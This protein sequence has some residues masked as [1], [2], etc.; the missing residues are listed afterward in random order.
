MKNYWEYNGI[1]EAKE[2]VADFAK[3]YNLSEKEEKELF[4]ALLSVTVPSTVYLI[5]Y[6]E[7]FSKCS[8][9][10]DKLKE[11]EA[12]EKTYGYI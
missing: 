10:V 7:H 9:I 1:T 12:K 2:K 5:D 3:S 4:E 6:F 8:N 11:A